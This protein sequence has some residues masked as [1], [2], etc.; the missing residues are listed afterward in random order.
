VQWFTWETFADFAVFAVAIFDIPKKFNYLLYSCCVC[1]G[2]SFFDLAN[3]AKSAKNVDTLSR[4]EL[5]AKK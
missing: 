2:I 3:L 1:E 4:K 5:A